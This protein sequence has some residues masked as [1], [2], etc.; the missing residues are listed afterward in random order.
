MS[1]DK[2]LGVRCVSCRAGYLGDSCELP[3][4]GSVSLRLVLK[5]GKQNRSWPSE[6][7][8]QAAGAMTGTPLLAPWPTISQ[9]AECCGVHRAEMYSKML[10]ILRSGA[11]VC[12]AALRRVVESIVQFSCTA[13]RNGIQHQAR[14]TMPDLRSASNANY[15]THCQSS[16]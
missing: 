3:L 9:A 6:V 14:H 7:S 1:Y 13:G 12:A 2:G 10:R 4:E 16:D 8:A 5:S 11:S 15:A